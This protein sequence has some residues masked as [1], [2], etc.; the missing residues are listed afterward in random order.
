MPQKPTASKVLATAQASRLWK[1]YGFEEPD[2][3][4]LE[5]LAY[6][7]GIV[8]MD[9]PLEGAD[10]WL[11]R[12]GKS[13][14][15]RVSD[16]IREP[17]RRRFGIAHEMGH[18]SLHEKISQLLACT[19]EDMISQ[20]KSSA[21]EL[22]ANYFAAELLMPRHLFSRCVAN[23]P[24]TSALVND[25]AAKFRTTR[26]ATAIRIADVSS[27]YFAVIASKDGVI[28][29]WQ[30]T[31]ALRE[32]IW[33]DVGGPVPRYSVAAQFF[34]GET[35]PTNPEK[36]E[37]DGWISENRGLYDDYVFED[38]IPMPTYGLVLSLVWLG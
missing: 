12:K 6:A 37:L 24:P 20:Y 25:L 34:R 22:E 28:Q 8:V 30:A 31:E 14:I 27:D 11:V 1:L 10:A 5:D 7:M 26:T 9:G 18:W 33:I 23:V 35:L 13:G 17:G 16:S 29:W 21:P 3:L 15:I 2:D 19:S 38:V 4:E 32:K 36:V